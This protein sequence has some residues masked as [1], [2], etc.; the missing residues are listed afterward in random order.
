MGGSRSGRNLEHCASSTDNA[1]EAANSGSTAFMAS[2]ARHSNMAPREP[3]VPS[4]SQVARLG[5]SF[6]VMAMAAV[7]PERLG[8]AVAE[9]LGARRRC[10]K[11]LAT[12]RTTLSTLSDEPGIWM[13]TVCC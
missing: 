1:Y 6:S 12:S 13:L 7:Y 9:I 11:R 10:G 4:A 2:T 5:A 3:G 8:F